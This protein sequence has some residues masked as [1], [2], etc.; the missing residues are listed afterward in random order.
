VGLK[1][2]LESEVDAIFRTEWKERDGRKVP[3][4]E[5]VKLGNEAVKLE[6]TVLYADLAD[7]TA[8]VKNYHWWFAA[9]VYKAYLICACKIIHHN[10]GVITAFDGDRV[11]ALYIGDWRDTAAAR[12]GLQISYAVNEI[13]NPKIKARFTTDFVM[14]QSVGIER[15]T[16]RAVRTGIHGS[17][18]LVWVGTAANIAAKLCNY[19]DGFATHLTEDVYMNLDNS[20]V[21]GG[22]SS[23]NMWSSAY[24]QEQGKTIYC[25]NWQWE[26]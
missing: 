21:Y 9:E 6:G 13:I 12:T 8:L 14:E 22:N 7:S 25:S 1:Q 19:Q 24:W 17:N 2:E 16:L 18:D 26:P 11:M 4:P 5:D 15:S 20:V 10:D 3:E 23:Q